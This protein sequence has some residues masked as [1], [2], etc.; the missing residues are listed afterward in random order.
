[1]TPESEAWAIVRMTSPSS[2][3]EKTAAR[4][5]LGEKGGVWFGDRINYPI[6][7]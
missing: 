6:S 2:E 3:V 1:M 7:T 5:R 4:T